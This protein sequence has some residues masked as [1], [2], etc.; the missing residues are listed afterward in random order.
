[1]KKPHSRWSDGGAILNIPLYKIVC[2]IIA[3]YEGYRTKKMP[4]VLCGR[5]Q[6]EILERT[7]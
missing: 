1:M 5:F 2:P 7:F 4:G 6:I 3:A